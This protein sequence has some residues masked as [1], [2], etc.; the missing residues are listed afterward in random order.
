V[1]NVVPPGTNDMVDILRAYAK[2]SNIHAL[3]GHA[4]LILLTA[5]V[6]MLMA[7]VSFITRILTSAV[8]LYIFPFILSI[9]S[10]KP[11]PPP[12]PPAKEKMTDY[13]GF[14]I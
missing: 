10:K 6:A 8:I 2:Q 3:G 4:I 1:I 12:P 7:D 9:V 14:P 5:L 11:A 13:R